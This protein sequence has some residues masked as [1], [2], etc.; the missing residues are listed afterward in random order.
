MR[1]R[2]SRFFCTGNLGRKGFFPVKEAPVAFNHRPCREFPSSSAI[3]IDSV[4]DYPIEFGLVI[5]IK[6]CEAG[7]SLLRCMISRLSIVFPLPG[8]QLQLEKYIVTWRLGIEGLLIS[9]TR[10]STAEISTNHFNLGKRYIRV[11]G[12]NTPL[13]NFIFSGPILISRSLRGEM[14]RSTS[15]V[16]SST[17]CMPRTEVDQKHDGKCLERW[18]RKA[19]CRLQG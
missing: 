14:V 7:S 3:D 12:V 2:V 19:P 6:D 15:K 1:E 16:S 8:I 17:S 10:P 18:H 9:E 4:V 5:G 11:Q 13:R